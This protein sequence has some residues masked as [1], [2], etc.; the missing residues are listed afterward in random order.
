MLDKNAAVCYNK[1]IG[2]RRPPAARKNSPVKKSQG[3]VQKEQRVLSVNNIMF[4]SFKFIIFVTNNEI[5]IC[6]FC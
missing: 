3:N 2:P 6:D 5:V 1:K 4:I